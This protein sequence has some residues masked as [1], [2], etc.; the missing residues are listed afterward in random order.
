M[1]SLIPIPIPI[2][3]PNPSFFFSLLGS[4]CTTN[5]LT[6]TVVNVLPM[7]N[8]R[9]RGRG[10]DVLLLRF[11]FK[12]KKKEKRKKQDNRYFQNLQRDKL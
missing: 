1:V 11:G 8:V 5:F 4:I 6:N 12:N 2:P 3:N 7:R 9:S 10:R